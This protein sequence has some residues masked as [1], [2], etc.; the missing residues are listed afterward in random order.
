MGKLQLSGQAFEMYIAESG[1]FLLEKLSSIQI[2]TTISLPE[3]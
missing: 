1:I 3:D 2:E